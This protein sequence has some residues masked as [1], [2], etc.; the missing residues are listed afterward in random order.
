[1]S[2]STQETVA[3]V[4]ETAEESF[5]D[6]LDHLPPEVA[7]A[8]GKSKDSKSSPEP[9]PTDAETEDPETETETDNDAPEESDEES[10]DDQDTE[11]KEE[12]EEEKPKGI[13]KLEKRI[14]K[15]TRRRKEAESVAESLRAENETLKAEVEKRSVIKLEP[16]ADDPLA[17]LDSMSDLE[18]KVSAAKK[19]RAWALANPDGA[20]VTNPDG[21]E[22]YVDRGEIAK[23]V[24]QTDALLT[25]H[26]PA[27][28]E[29]L[30]QREAILPEAKA[31]Y[32]DLFKV[33]SAE[34]KIMV[35]TL[36]QVP[37]LKR[38]PGYEMVIGDA[39]LGMKYRIEA[40]KSAQSK[41]APESK[42]S[43]A[44]K[45]ST[46]AALG[47]RKVIAPAI[48]KPSASRPPAASTK[49]KSNR[50]DRVIGSGSVDDLAAYFGG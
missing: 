50:L 35:D 1:M 32:P 23:F 2:E 10:K 11:E 5:S 27:R 29:Y 24:A 38:L 49:G 37:A 18:S 8:L 43:N 22:R 20:A 44:A 15:L 31:A 25:D 46:T 16:T 13:E 14:D 3:P 28:K 42:G 47:A 41:S 36:K 12:S 26:A 19:V 4:T 6:I 48:P 17:D 7:Q 30:A 21:S 34:H 9:E 45:S 40:S 33:G 39:L